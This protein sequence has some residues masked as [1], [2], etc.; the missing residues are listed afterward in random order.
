[1]AGFP[2]TG[3]S[4]LDRLSWVLA[5]ALLLAVSHL[6]A[7]ESVRVVVEAP[8]GS[9]PTAGA[10]VVMPDGQPPGVPSPEGKPPVEPPPG[11]AKPEGKPPTGEGK[12][13]PGKKGEPETPKPVTRPEKPPVPPDPREL[14]VTPDAEGLVRFSFR[15]QAWPDVLDWLARVCGRSLDWQELPGDY[16]NLTTQRGYTLEEAKDLINRHLLARGFTLLENGE[17]LSVFNISKI[18]PGMVPRVAPEELATMSPHA[19]VKVSFPLDWLMAEMAVEELKPMLSP[20]G[21]LTALT[22][23]NRL[24]AMDAAVNLREI[25]AVLQSEQSDTGQERLVKEFVLQYAKAADVLTQLQS[26][27]GVEKKSA[28][29]FPMD[30][31]QME[32]M[33]QQQAQMMAQ[34]QQQQQQQQQQQLAAGQPARRKPP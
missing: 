1:M 12:P 14:Q 34:M 10:V 31:Q 7:Q 9:A 32:M 4:A 5:I 22:T 11:G 26:L 33:Q 18:N 17:V 6:A 8:S 13:E 29:P 2:M 21:K 20:N 19:F 24:E 27:L 30:P 16:L 28:S 23:T 15:G 3:R 25:Y